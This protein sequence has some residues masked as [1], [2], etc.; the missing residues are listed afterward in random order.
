MSIQDAAGN[1]HDGKG[2]FTEKNLR[3]A[4]DGVLTPPNAKTMSAYYRE[5]A[6]RALDTADGVIAAAAR[7]R[8]AL[9]TNLA[10]DAILTIWPDAAN[11]YVFQE[12]D[13]VD[14]EGWSLERVY[15]ADGEI[16]FDIHDSDNDTAKH[17]Q[18][19]LARVRD[20]DSFSDDRDDFIS[21]LEEFGR[22]WQLDLT[23]DLTAPPVRAADLI[24][25][26]NLDRS[27]Q[28]ELVQDGAYTL[29]QPIIPASKNEFEYFLD[30]GDI[31]GAHQEELARLEER[32]G[33]REEALT[34]LV[35]TDAWAE[36]GDDVNDLVYNAKEKALR[37]AIT[38]ALNS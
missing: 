14:A 2:L 6:L 16:L 36:F 28:T 3:D 5:D 22:S 35:S 25:F 24:G 4:E 20:V 23:R 38:E 15:D 18:E 21:N 9:A 12:D 31:D 11:A 29:G 30:E 27:A 13:N 33:G 19:L 7:N 10:V 34:A 32:F 17:I 37:A 26:D 8:D 1:L